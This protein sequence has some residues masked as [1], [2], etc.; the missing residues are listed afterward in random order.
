MTCFNIDD[1]LILPTSRFSISHMK[2]KRSPYKRVA[3]IHL[4]EM[5][6]KLTLLA[7]VLLATGICMVVILKGIIGLLEN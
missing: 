2:K 1:S 3:E 7:S 4:W 5:T 6:A